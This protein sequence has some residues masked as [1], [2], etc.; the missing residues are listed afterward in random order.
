VKLLDRS[1]LF[2]RSAGRWGRP[3]A[4]TAG[5]WLAVAA[6]T[7]TDAAWDAGS[8][9]AAEG[10]PYRCCGCASQRC[11]VEPGA[12]ASGSEVLRPS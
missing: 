7:Q 9:N 1:R 2:E 6:G 3:A 8:R 12:D 5:S 4:S 10:V 11:G